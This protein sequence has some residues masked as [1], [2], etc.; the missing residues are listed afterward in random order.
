MANHTRCTPPPHEPQPIRRL[1]PRATSPRLT[2]RTPPSTPLP[3]TTPK[4]FA[5][6]KITSRHQ[7]PDR[8]PRAQDW[9]TAQCSF[10]KW[11]T[12]RIHSTHQKG[13]RRQSSRSISTRMG[14]LHGVIFR[15]AVPASFPEGSRR[16]RC[17]FLDP[18]PLSRPP[19]FYNSRCITPSRVN[20]PD[21]R[22]SSRPPI[23]TPT[24]KDTFPFRK[25]SVKDGPRDV[26]LQFR[27]RGRR[28]RH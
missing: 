7:S 12:R 22:P 20:L 15:R 10:Q 18:R 2:K 26:I 4:P 23:S 21:N 25:R 1:R 9:R 19:L 6:R 13:R 5:C 28:R 11:Q 16:N 14:S 24:L 8:N 17:R 3:P 27:W